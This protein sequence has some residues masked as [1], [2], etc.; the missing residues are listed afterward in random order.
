MKNL[1][2]C[3]T[4]EFL[5]QVNKIRH[6]AE[7]FIK[8]TGIL[9]IR[10]QKAVITDSMTD[11]EKNA[12]YKKQARVNL[13]DM[14]DACLDTNAEKTVEIIGLCCFKDTDESK[15]MEVSE[16]LD[17][18]FDLLG[19]QRVLDFFT[20]LMKSGLT[21]TADTSSEPTSKN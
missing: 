3:T 15:D 10:R 4:V 21:D 18:A 5:R 8:D 12:V 11:E 13:S 14:L 19:S 17:V 6:A 7:G 9:E 20:R 16:L 1:A 2:N